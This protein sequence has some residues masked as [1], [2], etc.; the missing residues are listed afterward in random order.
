MLGFIVCA[1][2]PDVVSI[3]P[4]SLEGLIEGESYSLRCDILNVAPVSNLSVHWHRGDALLYTERF[5]G[6]SLS[7]VNKTSVFNLSAQRGDGETPIW[8]EAQLDFWRPVP[9][10]PTIKSESRDVT[11]LYPPAFTEPNNETL[12]LSDGTKLILNCTAAGKPTPV[13][14]WRFPHLIQ[15]T[16]QNVNQ[17]VLAPPLQLPG[18]YACT[19]SNSQGS[20]TKYFTVTKAPRHRT[21]VAALVGGGVLLA[22]VIFIVGLLA[23]TT[24]GKISFGKG[25]YRKGRSTSSAPI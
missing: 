21:V 24:E 9:N 5:G 4:P 17:S 3:S 22:V 10:L 23:L 19:A 12:E 2:T 15:R 25:G 6:S 13:Y 16:N 18:T 20:E 8:C 1:E 7:P 14:S 11:V